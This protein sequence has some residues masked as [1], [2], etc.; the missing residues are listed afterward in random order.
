[1]CIENIIAMYSWI[2]FNC[3]LFSFVSPSCLLS[4]PFTLKEAMVCW[5]HVA[6]LF[7]Q[8]VASVTP[9]QGRQAA[10]HYTH[11]SPSI[12]A[13]ADSP[14]LH[15]FIDRLPYFCL[16]LSFIPL[17]ALM[18][19]CF[20]CPEAVPVLFHVRYLLNIH[21]LY[22]LLVSQCLSSKNADTNFGSI[23]EFFF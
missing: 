21:S 18:L 10:Y 19:F 7:Y 14:E 3:S 12:R 4:F 11:L 13:S 8:M 17:S 15:H 9:A 22:L 6:V 5:I 23:R 2:I 1:M 20:P 16:F